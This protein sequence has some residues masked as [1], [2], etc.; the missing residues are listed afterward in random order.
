MDN[1]EKMDKE[2][3]FGT[4]ARDYTHFT[5]GR[6]ARIYTN[7]NIEFIDFSSGIGVNSLGHANKGL[8]EVIST[9]AGKILHSSNLFLIEPQARLAKKIVELSGYKMKVFFSNSGLEANE[10]AIKLARKYGE[11][12]N[13]FKIITLKNSFHGRSITTLKACAQ[14]K[15]HKHFSP[16]PDGFIY[17]N[18]IKEAITLAKEDGKVVGIMLE[19]IQGEGG[20][21]AFDKNE[22]LEL[23]QFCKNNDILLMIDEVQSGI[24]RSGEFLASQVYNI[25]PDIISLAKGLAGGIPIGATISSKD[26]FEIGDH[27]STFGG[28]FLST[29]ASLYVLDALDSYKKSGDLALNIELFENYLFELK[30]NFSNIILDVSGL[31]FMRGLRLINDEVLANIL[32]L[33]KKHRILVLKSGNATLRFLPPINISKDEIIEG[34]SRLKGVLLEL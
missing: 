24:Y 30:N 34:F 18:D 3:V 26:V 12:K 15:M 9:Q 4:Y 17:A 25:S 32:N 23:S 10:C 13:R 22:V 2:Y 5:H 7:D 6:G 11:N 27:G 8:V 16:F 19:L 29:S 1:L 21:R 20:V 31:G 14:D 28:N 33:A